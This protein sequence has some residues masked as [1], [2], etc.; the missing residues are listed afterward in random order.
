MVGAIL[1]R[2]VRF[3]EQSKGESMLLIMEVAGGVV[4]GVIVL[5]VLYGVIPEYG[6]EIAEGLTQLIV[7]PIVFLIGFLLVG[8]AC[9]GAQTVWHY[10]VARYTDAESAHLFID[11]IIGVGVIVGPILFFIDSLN[12][13]A[14]LT[15]PFKKLRRRP[16]PAKHVDADRFHASDLQ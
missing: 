6:S 3:T 9:W 7:W 15:W 16:R 10:M 13:F 5:I 1:L 2:Y 14:W 8:F 12:N 4:F 11:P